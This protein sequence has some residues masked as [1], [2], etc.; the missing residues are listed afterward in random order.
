[1]LTRSNYSKY[2][3]GNKGAW[4]ADFVSWCA[5][6]AGVNSIAL[7]SSCYYM[8]YGML[9][10]GCQ[11]VTDPQRGDIVFFYCTSCSGTANQWCHVGIMV[12]STTSIDGNYSGKVSYD[13]SYSHYGSLGYKHSGG[14]TKKYVRPNYD[15]NNNFP[16]PEDSFW[17]K[18]DCERF[19]MPSSNTEY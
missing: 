2:Y 9:D 8:Y 18:H 14:I 17:H 19:V 11:V 12:D 1:M 13:S 5:Q 16:G 15:G 4:C 6:Q 7:S 10:N 3:G